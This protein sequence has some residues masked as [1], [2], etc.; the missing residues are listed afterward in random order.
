VLIVDALSGQQIKQISDPQIP[1]ITAVR[2]SP[3]GSRMALGT[4]KSTSNTT[5]SISIWGVADGMQRYVFPYNDCSEARWSP[6]STYVSCVRFEKTRSGTVISSF[7]Q[8]VIWV[9]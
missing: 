2:W 4:M 9:A 7:E 5:V 8:I 3:D 1:T 6:D